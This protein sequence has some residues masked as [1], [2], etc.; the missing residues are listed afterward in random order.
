M[1]LSASYKRATTTWIPF[2][3]PLIL[4][5]LYN[6]NSPLTTPSILKYWTPF[7]SFL[8]LLFLLGIGQTYAQAPEDSVRQRIR[9]DFTPSVLR[10]GVSLNDLIR[11][12]SNSQDTRYSV[13][14]DLALDRY[15]IV[16]D[17]GR[18]EATLE[19]DP[20]RPGSDPYSFSSQGSY[21][22][23]GVDVNLLKDRERNNYLADENIIF[24]GLRFARAQIDETLSFETN[25]LV[26]GTGTIDQTNNGLGITWAEMTAGV[27]VS[28]FRNIY[29]GYNLR[30]KFLRTFGEETALVPYQVPGFGRGNRETIFGFD[31]YLF[32]RIPFRRR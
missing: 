25:D 27:K 31:Y 24:F 7:P 10:V 2:A 20:T 17:Y 14:A 23:A 15:M 29:L 26:W 16:V 12:L 5:A 1:H 3:L 22:R 6:A 8:S 21:F 4:F 32:Y 13:Q 9:K 28:V 30:F 18:S 11:T 19:N